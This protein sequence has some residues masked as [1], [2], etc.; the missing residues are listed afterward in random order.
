MLRTREKNIK[1]IMIF[2]LAV[3]LISSIFSI[4]KALARSDALTL[5]NVTITDQSSEVE[6]KVIDYDKE[7]IFTDV[8][9]HR[10]NDYVVYEL[11]IKNDDDKDYTINSISDDNKSSYITYEYDHHQQEKIISKSTKKILIKVIYKNEISDINERKQT[12]DVKIRMSLLDEDGNEITKDL[13]V[14]PKT[15]DPIGIYIIM[16]IIS[17]LGLI[18]VIVDKRVKKILVVLLLITPIITKAISFSFAITLK[19]SIKLYDKLLIT[20]YNE[21]KENQI[22]EYNTKID[23]PEK[24]EKP[25]YI[26]N[27]WY[28]NNELYDFD[29]PVTEDIVLEANYDLINYKINYVLNDGVVHGNPIEYNVETDTFDLINPSKEGYTFAGWTGSNGDTLQTRVTIEKGSI[30]DKTFTANYLPDSNTAYKVIHKYENLDGTYEVVEENLTGATNSVVRPAIQEKTGVVNPTLV[31]VTIKADGTSSVEYIYT[32]EKYTLTLQNEEDIETTFINGEY[33]YETQITLTA[34]EKEGYV[35]EKWSDDRIEN[36]I[37]FQL[38][39]NTEIGPIYKIQT[40]TVIFNSQGGSSIESITKNNNEK[41]GTLPTPT[42]EKYIF[43]GWYTDASEGTKITD[44]TLITKDVIY[45]AH[46]KRVV[47]KAATTLHTEECTRTSDG[48][49]SSGYREGG[50]KGTTTI[51]YG[52]IPSTSFV[53]GDAY[54]CDVNGDGIYDAINERFYYL[55]DNGT[56]AVLIYYTNYDGGKNQCTNIFSYNDALAQLPEIYDWKNIT[57]NYDYKAARLVS[58]TDIE[59][60]CGITVGSAKK[61]ELEQCTYLLENTKYQDENVCRY[62]YWTEELSS[63]LYRVGSRDRFVHSTSDSSNNG[64]RPVIEVPIELMELG[65]LQKHTVTFDA[66]GGTNVDAIEISH[67]STIGVLPKP[68]KENY[69]FR[70]WYTD[71]DYITKVTTATVITEDVT[72]YAKWYDNSDTFKEIFRHDGACTFNGA[73]NPITGDDCSE[74]WDQ[75]YIDT[76]IPLYNEENYQKDFEIGFTIVNYD[77]KDQES[78]VNQTIMSDKNENDGSSDVIVPGIVFRKTSETTLELSQVVGDVKK[79]APLNYTKVQKVRIYRIDHK[80]YYS[81]NDDNKKLLQDNSSFSEMFDLP[82]IFGAAMKSTGEAFRHVKATISNMY[83]KL[84]TYTENGKYMVTF[85]PNGGSV[86]PQTNLV[87]I[88][89]SIGFLPV[90]T[91]NGYFFDGWYT[92]LVGGTKIDENTIPISNVTYYANW[93]KSI[94]S[95]IITNDTMKLDIS[96]SEMINIS[97]A[98]EISEEYIFRSNNPRIATVDQN[99]KVTGIS[100]GTT[101]IMIKGLSSD[102]VESVDVAVGLNSNVVVFNTTNDVIKK[103]YNNLSSWNTS[104]VNFINNMKNNFENSQCKLNSDSSLKYTSGSV[105]CDKPNAYDTKT[106]GKLNVYLY[107]ID[108]EEKEKQVYYTNSDTGILYNMIP[109]KTYYWE[110]E[111]DSSQNGYVMALGNRRFIETFEVRNVRDLGGLSVDVDGDNIPDGTLKYEKIFRGEKLWTNA[112]NVTK[113]QNLGITKEIDLREASEVGSDVK[114]PNYSLNTIIH[115]EIDKE[116]FS[117]NYTLA[118]NTVILIMKDVVA[119]ENIYFHC[120]LGAD[121]TGTIA[122][123]LEGLLGVEDELRY[124]DYELT[125]F[126]GLTDRTRYYRQNPSKPTMKKFI[127]MVDVMQTKEDVMNWFLEGSENE[128]EDRTLIDQFRNAMIDWN[129]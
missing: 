77:P 17:F 42:K 66:M 93:K 40:Y 45:Y 96:N 95:A 106:N 4:E 108:K 113:L 21:E 83:V 53:S 67:N 81:I 128:A 50:S 1:K 78:G 30:G 68:T 115:Y 85:D 13:N 43:D 32:R 19:N 28:H 80:I 89:S 52:K 127:Y 51:T 117:S 39:D 65:S 54:D 33:P 14:N 59:K 118:R 31:D 75:Y 88:D 3:I 126:Y 63:T 2:S 35:F 38:K 44:E 122:Y 70:G 36:P 82:L 20:I 90:P 119:G 100:Q 102:K 41:I 34:K 73:K 23:E 125:F 18:L 8:I 26:F 114:M 56:N 116:N 129:S 124:E 99:G 72:L 57:T 94:E 22:I 92:S 86:S 76:E 9:F 109:G 91:R 79:T 120:R 123:I 55:R 107:N 104:E 16:A 24:S 103:Y 110:L 47:C 37:T 111:S 69:S 101:T 58:I 48:C 105:L 11:K 61:G 74:Y 5:T 121:R 60:A 64:S 87:E 71:T 27:G 10:V 12:D 98:S 112:S 46:W 62:G 84:G 25:G 15:G 49:Y 97:N 7:T 6:A 29:Q